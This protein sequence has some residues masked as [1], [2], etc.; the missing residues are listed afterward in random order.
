MFTARAI[1]LMQGVL[2]MVR[3]RYMLCECD[4]TAAVT[5]GIREGSGADIHLPRT[6]G[7]VS[8]K[9]SYHAWCVELIELYIVRRSAKEKW[10]IRGGRYLGAALHS[11]AALP[12]NM[13]YHVTGQIRTGA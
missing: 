4:D 1:Q 10:P 8:S 5:E 12:R 2:E 9:G 6:H 7:R 13:T 11:L 3:F